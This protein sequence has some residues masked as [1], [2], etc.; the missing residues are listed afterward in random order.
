MKAY[1]IWYDTPYYIHKST[2]NE[3][4]VKWTTEE[5]EAKEVSSF[6]EAVN[7]FFDKLGFS[8]NLSKPN[9]LQILRNDNS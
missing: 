7:F 4:N 5:G 3:L 9:A 2:T 6:R 8:L 1:K